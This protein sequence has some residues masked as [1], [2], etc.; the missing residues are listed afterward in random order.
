M[1]LNS[2]YS[3]KSTSTAPEAPE[4]HIQQC[5]NNI[6]LCQP[7]P[8]LQCLNSHLPVSFTRFFRVAAG[9][10]FGTW[11]SMQLAAPSLAFGTRQAA[12]LVA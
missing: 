4:P 1:Q 7:F 8:T 3:Y 2:S 11:E 12:K 6:G 9:P 10:V 5:D